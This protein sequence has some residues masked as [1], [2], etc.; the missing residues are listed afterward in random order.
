MYSNRTTF[1]PMAEHQVNTTLLHTA[2][3]SCHNQ[4][5]FIKDDMFQ[6]NK[7][8][9]FSA[10]GEPT[11]GSDHEPREAG[12]WSLEWKKNIHINGGEKRHW[13]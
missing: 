11:Y 8:L 7:N 13:F 4:T 6:A 12:G 3:H 5:P 2:K 1:V 10:R 9:R